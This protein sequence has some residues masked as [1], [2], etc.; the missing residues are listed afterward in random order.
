MD[1]KKFN[2]FVEVARDVLRQERDLWG[3]TPAA[4]MAR[5][6]KRRAPETRADFLRDMFWCSDEITVAWDSLS[7]IAQEILRDGESLPAELAEWVADR[8][9]GKKPR[10][11][12]RGQD[13]DAKSNRNRS[14]MVA[15]RYLVSQGMTATRN[16]TEVDHAC[17]EG[18]SA[19][20]AVG[21]AAKLGYKTVEKIWSDSASPNSPFYRWAFKHVP[22]LRLPMS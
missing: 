8:L 2:Q 11:T 13:S 3:E 22:R 19:C 20:D 7:L 5:L 14:V 9:A 15:V 10:P 17:F 21:L 4:V 16:K 18:G 6:Y 1:E 12:Q